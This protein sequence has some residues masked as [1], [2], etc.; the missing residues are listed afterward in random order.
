MNEN[1]MNWQFSFIEVVGLWVICYFACL[2]AI[3][4]AGWYQRVQKRKMMEDFLSH[5]QQ[6]IQTEEEFQDIIE[7]MRRD[8]GGGQ[9]NIGNN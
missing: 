8:F 1:I 3:G 9:D 5:I 6:K 2:F 7:K 4:T